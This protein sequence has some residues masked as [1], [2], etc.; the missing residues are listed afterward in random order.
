MVLEYFEEEMRKLGKDNFQ[1]CFR[2]FRRGDEEIRQRQVL[3]L[4]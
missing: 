3:K 4:S 1:N 2:I